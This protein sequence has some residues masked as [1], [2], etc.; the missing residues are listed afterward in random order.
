[1]FDQAPS[2]WNGVEVSVMRT[3]VRSSVPVKDPSEVSPAQVD[4]KEVDETEPKTNAV[5]RRT[6]GWA[7]DWTDS[8]KQHQVSA[9]WPLMWLTLPLVLLV[10]YGLFSGHR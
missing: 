1:L 4:S 2:D 8:K 3:N 10:L 7:E 5:E 6:G 9:L